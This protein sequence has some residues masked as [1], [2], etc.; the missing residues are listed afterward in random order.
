MVCKGIR[1]PDSAWVFLAQNQFA[2]RIF[3]QSEP[4]IEK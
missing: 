4:E 2:I 3:T 1:D